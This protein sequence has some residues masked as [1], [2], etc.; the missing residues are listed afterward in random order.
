MSTQDQIKNLEVLQAAVEAQPEALFD[1]SKYQ[2]ATPCGTLFCTIG[3]ATT[4]PHFQQQGFYMASEPLPYS[5]RP[6]TGVKVGEKWIFDS[7][8][9]PQFF[10]AHFDDLFSPAGCGDV[11]EDLGYYYH[12]KLD[13]YSMTDRELAIARI[14]YQLALLQ[15]EEA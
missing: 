4:L 13:E 9:A 12:E 6:F 8:V 10:G 14:E 11:D 3:L 5:E 7:G 1:L 2:Q 15:P